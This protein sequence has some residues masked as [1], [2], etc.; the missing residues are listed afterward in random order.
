MWKSGL[1]FSQD[2]FY[3]NVDKSL[4]RLRDQEGIRNLMVCNFSC[5][6]KSQVF[7][8]EPR[9]FPFFFKC[10][11]EAVLARGDKSGLTLKE[12]TVL[13]VF[14]DHCFNSLVCA[15]KLLLS[16]AYNNNK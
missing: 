8:K 3:I 14:L 5:L 11:M 7:K 1:M 10:V 2:R 6:W 4:L 15:R 16:T 12:Q 13:L 9:H